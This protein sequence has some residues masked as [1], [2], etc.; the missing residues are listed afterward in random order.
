MKRL[1]CILLIFCL[2]ASF[3]AC[4]IWGSRL[5]EPVTFY[6]QRTNY[7]Y[8][9]QDG[10]IY[11]EERESSGHAEDLSFLLALYIAGP[12]SNELTCPFPGDTKLLSV[13]KTENIVQIELS[14]IGNKISDSQ[15]SLACACMTLTCLEL[16]DVPNVTILSGDRITQLNRDSI[17]MYDYISEA[18]SSEENK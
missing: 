2:S 4:S 16:T 8:N 3:C 9:A 6:Y 7:Q 15:F 10:V 5:K 1:I 14:D 17:L 13:T 12:V 18:T 11:S